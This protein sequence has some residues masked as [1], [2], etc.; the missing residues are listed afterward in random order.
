MRGKSGVGGGRVGTWEG[1]AIVGIT[2]ATKTKISTPPHNVSATGEMG[3]V[4]RSGGDVGAERNGKFF[5]SDST[6]LTAPLRGRLFLRSSSASTG[7][8]GLDFG[9]ERMRG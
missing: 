9:L 8:G 5:A 6:L 7:K 4:S 2:L 3:N 1:C